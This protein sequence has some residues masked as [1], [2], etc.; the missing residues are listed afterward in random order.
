MSAIDRYKEAKNYAEK[1]RG[2]ANKLNAHGPRNVLWNCDKL[3]ANVKL[4]NTHAGTYGN[5]S[6]YPWGNEI[7]KEMETEIGLSF[8]NLA[9]SA[10]KRCEKIAE[11]RRF[12]ARKEA[13]DIL[14]DIEE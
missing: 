12:E 10:A 5:S 3:G 1:I 2:F 7:I 13:E 14:K 11:T 6:A 4:T 9:L 8:R